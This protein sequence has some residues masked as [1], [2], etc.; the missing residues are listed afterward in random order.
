MAIARVGR[1]TRLPGALPARRGDE[2]VPL[3][4]GGHGRTCRCPESVPERYAQRI[5]G[6]L[7]DRID[8]WVSMPRVPAAAIVTAATPEDSRDG[9]RAGS[10]GHASARSSDRAGGSTGGSV[11]GRC[12]SPADSTGRQSGGPI[13]LAE[14]ERL[15]GRGTERLLRVARTIADLAARRARRARASRGG[16]PVPSAGEP[17]RA[18]AGRLMLGVAAEGPLGPT[19][20]P[21]SGGA[22]SGTASGLSERQA[23]GGARHGRRP[24][25]G[26]A[27]S[28]RRRPRVGAGGA[29]RRPAGRHPG[30]DRGD[31][32][33]SSARH[34]ERSSQALVERSRDADEIARRIERAAV[35]LVTLDDPDYPARLRAIELPPHVLFVRGSRGRPATARAVAVVGTRRPTEA[36]RLDGRRGSPARSPGPAR[37]SCPGSPS[38][39]T[40]RRTPPRSRRTAR[41]SPSSAAVTTG[42][43]RGPTAARRRDRGRRRRRR[44]GAAAGRG[45]RP[46]DVPAA[47]PDHQRPVRGDGRRRGRGPERRAD[48]GRPG[49]SSRA[50]SASSYPARSTRRR[51]AGCLALLRECARRRRGSSPGSRSCS[52]TSASL[53][54]RIDGGPPRRAGR[55]PPRWRTSARS[56]RR[57][58]RASSSAGARRRRRAGGRPRACPSRRSS[59]ALTLLEI[60]RPGRRAPTV[61]T[62]P[63]ARLARGDDR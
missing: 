9:R 60:A 31:E 11:A 25:T 16:G 42:S 33:T 53:E 48:H 28:P 52:R 62:V 2:P 19:G 39:S 38:A 1:A 24:R 51:V 13:E 46:R 3:R 35:D 10:H 7:R 57:R 41:R 32:A 54:R 27:G 37:P 47:Q 45:A 20:P 17:A 15:S 8:L 34:L 23:L 56:A 43:S 30:P 50:A 36:G 5:S 44:L 21:P 49:R 12:A 55:P 4:P 22:A 59:A 29:R 61:A 18:A 14:M 26:D 6:P 40:G 63:R 58:R